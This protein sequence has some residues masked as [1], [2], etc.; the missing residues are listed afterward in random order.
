MFKRST[1][2]SFHRREFALRNGLIL[3]KLTTCFIGGC[4]IFNRV[5]FSHLN[6][7][8][9]LNGNSINEM[10]HFEYPDFPDYLTFILGS[11]PLCLK[12]S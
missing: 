6:C 3:L 8:P 5:L 10:Q 7:F 12:D 9:A 2:G 4:F 11:F 1:Q